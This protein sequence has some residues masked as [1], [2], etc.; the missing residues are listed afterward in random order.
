M[1]IGVLGETKGSRVAPVL[2]CHLGSTACVL[3]LVL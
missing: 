2:Q 3:S 1:C